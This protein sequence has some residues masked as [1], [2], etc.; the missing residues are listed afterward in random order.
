V[1]CRRLTLHAD[2]DLRALATQL[3]GWTGAN[4]AELCDRA[5]EVAFLRGTD[6]RAVTHEDFVAALRRGV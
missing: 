4:L 1:H 5:A 6:P 3:Y 2:V